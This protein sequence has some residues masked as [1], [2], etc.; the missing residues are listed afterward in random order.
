MVSASQLES[1][2]HAIAMVKVEGRESG[3]R[4]TNRDLQ[5]L[6]GRAVLFREETA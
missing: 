1:F 2:Q 4:V 5:P 3:A 6:N